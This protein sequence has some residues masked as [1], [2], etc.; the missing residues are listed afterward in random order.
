MII[1]VWKAAKL[2]KK[3]VTIQDSVYS[4]KIVCS[5]VNDE[6][7]D[8]TQIVW[9]IKGWLVATMKSGLQIA[10]FMNFKLIS[11]SKDINVNHITNNSKW[12]FTQ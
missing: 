12:V 9:H 10:S 11:I 4:T 5:F 1:N 8:K 7:G 3:S 6:L 2:S